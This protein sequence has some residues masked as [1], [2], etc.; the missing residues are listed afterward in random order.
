MWRLKRLVA[1][2]NPQFRAWDSGTLLAVIKAEGNAEK[3]DD[4]AQQSERSL[5]RE[6]AV[7]QPGDDQ[8]L[9]VTSQS[10]FEETLASNDKRTLDQQLTALEKLEKAIRTGR[11]LLTEEKE[12]LAELFGQSFVTQLGVVLPG[13]Y[14]ATGRGLAAN[15]EGRK[16]SYGAPEEHQNDADKVRSLLPPESDLRK[17]AKEF[18]LEAIVYKKEKITSQRE[19]KV[20]TNKADPQSYSAGFTRRSSA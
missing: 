15:I 7:L 3:S 18:L 9:A 8:D 12:F 16:K 14:E 2:E 4:R 13:G 19:G 20:A 11:S 5:H 6:D 10:E 17:A 1:F